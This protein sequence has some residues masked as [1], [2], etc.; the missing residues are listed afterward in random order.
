MIENRIANYPGQTIAIVEALCRC[1]MGNNPNA[2]VRK[3]IERWRDHLNGCGQII[4][5]CRIDE[6][7]HP[8]GLKDD[9]VIVHSQERQTAQ[10]S[11]P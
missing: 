2:A 7:L 11:Q 6:I 5:A 8:P 1:A 4:P 9:V 3:Q 10:E